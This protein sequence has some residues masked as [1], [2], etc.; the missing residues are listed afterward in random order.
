MPFLSARWVRVE[1]GVES[2]QRPGIEAYL[3]LR[4]SVVF[5]AGLCAPASFTPSVGWE[6]RVGGFD[7]GM[8]CG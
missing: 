1:R 5:V 6:K 8:R 2:R 4:Y 7:G 3:R